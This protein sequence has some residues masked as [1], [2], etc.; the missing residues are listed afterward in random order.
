MWW[1]N[2][3]NPARGT[4]RY[5][6]ESISPPSYMRQASIPPFY[7]IEVPADI[8][9]SEQHPE[10]A[11]NALLRRL[12]PNAM[13]RISQDLRIND[14]PFDYVQVANQAD[15]PLIYEVV[16]GPAASSGDN[17]AIYE[18]IVGEDVYRDT[19]LSI[20]DALDRISSAS[21]LEAIDVSLKTHTIS[22]FFP[23]VGGDDPLTVQIAR[24]KMPPETDLQ[25]ASGVGY[26]DAPFEEEPSLTETRLYYPLSFGARAL[27]VLSWL[28]DIQ[29]PASR[30]YL[31][32][33]NSAMFSVISPA[34]L[35]DAMRS[36]RVSGREMLLA[37]EE[38]ILG[39]DL[40]EFDVSPAWV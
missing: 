26:T 40:G 18:M 17:Y 23:S 29:G 9:I 19:S 36:F 34:V 15:V 39:D 7:R 30:P 33:A 31:R 4:V 3:G 24:I 8:G 2:P 37:G 12:L 25:V 21:G 38:I 1:F 14:D 6:E 11:G 5:A 20:D 10:A 16:I 35:P 32:F 27:W 28:G 13:T 22:D